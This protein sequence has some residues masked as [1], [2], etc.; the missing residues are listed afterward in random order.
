MYTNKRLKLSKRWLS[1]FFIFFF[2]TTDQLEPT[3]VKVFSI[4][5]YVIKF[6]SD[7]WQVDGFLRFPVTI[8]L[9]AT[10]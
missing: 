10:I 8:K 3:H 4:Q 2:D 7:L 6:V 9:I 1:V 5:L